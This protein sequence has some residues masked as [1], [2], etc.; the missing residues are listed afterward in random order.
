MNIT[1][2]NYTWA[3][4]ALALGLLLNTL[5][6]GADPPR[7]EPLVQHGKWPEHTRGTAWDVKVVGNLAYLALGSG[8]LM[9]LD[10]S[11]PTSPVCLGS[12]DTSGTAYG[13]AVVG[14]VA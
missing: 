4:L 11:N 12:Y 1:N 2:H 13:V 9:I 7:L 6:L 10:V 5:P 14:T 3:R 8:G